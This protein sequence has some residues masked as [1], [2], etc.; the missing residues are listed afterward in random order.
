MGVWS[1]L[2]RAAHARGGRV[3]V[4]V[5]DEITGYAIREAQVGRDVDADTVRRLGEGGALY[6]VVDYEGGAPTATICHRAQ[7]LRARSRHEIASQPV[8]AATWRKRD[9]LEI[10]GV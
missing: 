6:V 7:W 2:I 9:E 4:H 8:E 5:F 3:V 1:S 10:T